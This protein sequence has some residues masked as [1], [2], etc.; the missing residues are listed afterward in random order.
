MRQ[1]M[2]TKRV[3]MR[4][5][6]ATTKAQR[7]KWPHKKPRMLLLGLS[8]W[9]RWQRRESEGLEG[10]NRTMTCLKEGRGGWERRARQGGDLEWSVLKP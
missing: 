4:P 6:K 5:K 9:Q 3:E 7:P 1:G 10:L 2:R 8:K